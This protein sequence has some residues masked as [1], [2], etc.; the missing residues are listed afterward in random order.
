V[1]KIRILSALITL[2][3]CGFSAFGDE[4]NGITI[5]FVDIGNPGNV[6]DGSGFGGVSYSY[7]IG[8]YEIS[9]SQWATAIAD[10]SR[11]GDTGSGSGSQPTG[12]A[13]W[14]EAAKFANW[15]TSGDAYLGA[16]QFDG[17]GTLTNIS[18]SA[19]LSTYG[20]VY[21]LPTADEW[22]KAAYYNGLGYNQYANASNDVP[23]MEV[24]A[25]YGGNGG[26]YSTAWDVGTGHVELNGTYDMMGNVW[27]WTEGGDAALTT[28]SINFWGGSYFSTDLNQLSSG[29][30]FP[31]DA[32]LSD[33]RVG[34]RIA[35]IPEPGTMSMMSLS[36]IGL[37]FTRTVRRRKRLGQ[38]L[39]PIRRQEKFIDAFCTEEEWQD[40]AGETEVE[41]GLAILFHLVKE[42][43]AHGWSAVRYVYKIGD[44]AFW[45]FM[46]ARHERKLAR[47]KAFR[48]TV[49]KKSL[50]C[51]DGFLARIMK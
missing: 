34:M 30:P 6:N 38:S 51:L 40:A 49:R 24:A 16:Y 29:A 5:D 45:N 14:Y 50:D 8:K 42:S 13:T 20:T 43:C 15:L 23:S 21:V 22:Y 41:D 19:A 28:N 1:T 33:I 18:R 37:F 9:A 46:V 47:R 25:N 35:S 4:I 10:D 2:L 27:E 39:F 36:T 17:T 44:K 7:R 26:T 32:D 12:R 31:D 48:Q 11:I 3:S